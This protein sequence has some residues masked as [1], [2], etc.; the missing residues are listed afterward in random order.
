MVSFD[1]I[2]AV[3]FF[4]V[5]MALISPE[6]KLGGITPLFDNV[7]TKSKVFVVIPKL[8]E[9][10]LNFDSHANILNQLSRPLQQGSQCISTFPT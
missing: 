7:F 1:P 5:N 9:I 10:K 3:N 6:L 8:S 2:L 4:D